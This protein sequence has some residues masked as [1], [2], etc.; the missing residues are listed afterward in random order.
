MRK[1]LLILLCAFLPV[2]LF[3]QGPRNW[4]D[5][6][7]MQPADLAKVLGKKEQPVIISVGPGAPIPHSV[8]VGMTNE[9]EGISSLK[10][11]LAK[12]PK[13]QKLVIY[14]GC[15]PFEHC[16]NVRPA[17]STLKQLHYT[18]YFLLNLPNNIRTDWI[19]KGYPTNN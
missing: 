17:I 6:E 15:C 8:S 16:P 4:T 3:A 9:A 5:K 13:N 14:C 10:K 2:F 18:N 19:N 7:L 11:Q 1:Q 12:V